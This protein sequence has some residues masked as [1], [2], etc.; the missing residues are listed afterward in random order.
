MRDSD[1]AYEKIKMM[2]IT[3]RLKPGEAVVEARLMETLGMGRTPIREALNRLA[4]ENFVK[5]I[6]RQC[7][8]VNE[9]SIYEVESIYQMRFALAPLESELAALN[10]TDRDLEHLKKDI[11]ALS[12]ETDPQKRVRLDRAFHRTVSSMTK[13]P[14][15][16]KEMNN[17]QDLSIRLLFLN[18][19]NLS[20]IDDMDIGTHEKI[21][22][23][24][25]ERDRD[26][27]IQ[28]Q[29]NHVLEFKRKFIH[30]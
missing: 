7:I 15:L 19:V 4:W 8:M 17:Y 14:F 13:N 24:I 23:Y 22:R 20:A 3:A 26:K 6:P 11:E 2:I 9:I 27:L 30:S 5:I 21:Y 16:E 29:K 18:Q 28:V 1:V 25:Q 12:G 10:R